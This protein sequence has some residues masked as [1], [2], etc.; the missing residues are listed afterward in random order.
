MRKWLQKSHFLE[1]D[2]RTRPCPYP[3][4]AALLLNQSLYSAY[5]LLQARICS[6]WIRLSYMRRL[7]AP[8]GSYLL[9]LSDPICSA[10]LLHLLAHSIRSTCMLRLFARFCSNYLRPNLIHSTS[11]SYQRPPYK[12]VYTPLLHT[13]PSSFT[14]SPCLPCALRQWPWLL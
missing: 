1:V 13:H 7:S 11:P 10:N 4:T 8:T 2:P 9:H 14:R 3:L 12:I 5:L 6:A